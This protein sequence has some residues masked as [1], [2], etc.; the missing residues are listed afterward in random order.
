MFDEAEY[1]RRKAARDQLAEEI[2]QA[3]EADYHADLDEDDAKR[4]Q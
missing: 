2:W 1:N 4:N 3:D